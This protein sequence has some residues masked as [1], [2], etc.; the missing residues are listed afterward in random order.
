MGGDRPASLCNA[1]ALIVSESHHRSPV[2]TGC[3]QAGNECPHFR[4]GAFVDM[5]FSPIPPP[6]ARRIP[7]AT[8][9]PDPGAGTGTVGDLE[10]ALRAVA[11]PPRRPP[12]PP[13]SGACTW[14]AGIGETPRDGLRFAI[15]SLGFFHATLKFL[16]PYIHLRLEGAPLCAPPPRAPGRGRASRRR[17]PP[18][19]G[20]R[21]F[22]SRRRFHN[23]STP[24]IPPE[25][26][27]CS[28]LGS[29]PLA[30]FPPL[31]KGCEG[32]WRPPPP[33]PRRP[34][35]L[36]LGRPLPPARPPPGGRLLSCPR[37]GGG[38][39]RGG[40]Y[41]HVGASGGI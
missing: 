34:R 18:P 32:A 33:P 12:P 20:H 6:S 3:A 35:P 1:T 13:L 29:G 26:V 5:Y 7:P 41:N 19:G 17:T 40:C 14:A 36:A 23:D 38:W 11:P 24:T 28:Q 4:M 39:E 30:P 22:P 25:D 31:G 37:G 21:P 10:A 15:Q 2:A 27:S 8:T 16:G 9:D